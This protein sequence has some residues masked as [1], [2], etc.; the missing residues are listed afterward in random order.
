MERGLFCAEMNEPATVSVPP[1]GGVHI[2]Q[3]LRIPFSIV[4]ALA[5]LGGVAFSESYWRSAAPLVGS[6]LL[7][8]G[9]VLAAIGGFGRVWCSVYAA[10]YKNKVLITEGP[11]S[12]SRN[13]LYFFSLVGSLGVGLSTQTLTVPVVIAAVFSIYYPLVIRGESQILSQIH[14]DAYSEY[15]SK[16]PAFFPRRGSLVEPKTY[17]VRPKVIRRH[18][19]SAIWFVWFIAVILIFA[20]LRAIGLLPP[21]LTLY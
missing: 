13:P 9:V 19:A 5:V 7:A 16:V 15:L 2:W 6:L 12:M 14:G 1:P 8:T 4:F 3:R 20:G 21:L 17:T 11:Y 18:I 10:G